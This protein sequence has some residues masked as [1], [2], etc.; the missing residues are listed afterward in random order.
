MLV[1]AAA[2]IA[3]LGLA[4][5]AGAA[6]LTKPERAM[7]A[8]VEA[9]RERDIALLQR[10]VEIN[11]GTL[12]TAGV[13]A[14]GR[15]VGSELQELGFQVRWVPMTQTGRAGHLIA[16]RRAPRGKRLLLIGHLD[17]VFEPS[18]PFQKWVRRGDIAEGP[19]VGDMKGGIVVILSALR[20]MQSAGVLDD[21]DITVVLTGDEEKVGSPQAVARA[22]LIS[23]GRKADVALDFEGLAAED[24]HDMGSIARRSSAQWTVRATGRAGHS[25]GVF[26][27]AAGYGAAYE[28]ARI[29]DDFRKELPEP[30]L[31]FN[32]GLVLAGSKAEMD[33]DA[34][35]GS[36]EGK[37]NIIPGQ[38]IAV[39]DIRTLSEAQS[40]RVRAKMEAIVARHLPRTN[41][42]ISF[43][44]G[45]P[46]M[47]PTAG[48]RALLAALNDVNRDLGLPV[49]PELDPLKRGAGDIAFVAGDVD[50]LVGLGIAGQGAHAVGETADL[51]S[52]ERQAKRA[53]ILMHRLS[54][55]PRP[56]TR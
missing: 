36:A 26:S 53:A 8:S 7:S 12:N 35:A 42:E 10:L 11:S 34:S 3:A 45:Y 17:T 13:E 44:E 6:P 28:L 23:A 52:I 32:V 37:S 38:A 2:L 55:Q 15:I 48:A 39:G 46:A 14:V 19:G 27:E 24:G 1:R 21:A 41:A 18:S 4:V 20:A 43:S 51:R 50:G 47:A 25:S 29:L 33:A 16:E 9:S 40:A 30:S 5:P 22:D 54:R 31:T 49:Q 56:G